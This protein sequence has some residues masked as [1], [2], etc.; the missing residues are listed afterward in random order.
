[1]FQKLITALVATAG[2]AVLLP[3]PGSAH[4]MSRH[5][6]GISRGHR[7]VSVGA[8]RGLA[9]AGRLHH[10]AY[11]PGFRHRGYPYVPAVVGAGLVY[12]ATYSYGPTHYAADYLNADGYYDD[13]YYGNTGCVLLRKRV[14]TPYGWAL[15]PVQ[16]CGY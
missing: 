5:P 8:S 6:A 10:G 3:E 13:F 1:M 11:R 15:R 14:L 2:L 9:A 7:V 4:D 12:G 16:S